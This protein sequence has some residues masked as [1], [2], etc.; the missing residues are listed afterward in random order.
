MTTSELYT[1]ADELRTLANTGLHYDKDAYARERNHK[2]LELSARLVASVEG[3]D[4]AQVLRAY[5]GN[6]SRMSPAV[7][8]DLAVFREGRVLLIQRRDNGLWAL[9]GGVVDVGETLRE[10]AEREFL[11]EVGA[12]AKAT[13][14]LAILDSRVWHSRVRFQLYH[15]IFL[16]ELA[17]GI[18]PSPNLQGDGPTAETLDAAFFAEDA[19]PELHAGHHLWLGLIFQLYRRERAAPYLD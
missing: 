18:T 8:V 9:P 6:F 15:H 19:L 5:E 14:L 11:E 3:G 2:V 4:S 10:A 7:G 12:K 13:D 1:I 16:G 17:E